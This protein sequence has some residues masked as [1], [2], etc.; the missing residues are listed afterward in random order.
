MQKRL[1]YKGRR[2]SVRVATAALVWLAAGMTT[3]EATEAADGKPAMSWGQAIMLG[4]IEGL[5]E[6]LPVSS[7]AHLFVAQR[8]MGIGD[9]AEERIAA[10]AF[11]IT[12]QAGAILAVVW[13]YFR[14]LRSIAAGLLGGAP[15]G[16][17]LAGR[18]LLAFLP[19][20]ALGLA[21]EGVI[22][23][24]LFNPSAIAAAWLAGGAAILIVGRRRGRWGHGARQSLEE[25]TWRGALLIG[26]AQCAALWPGVSRSLAT[27]VGGLLAG[28][29]VGAAVEFSFLLGLLTLGAATA[30]EMLRYGGE[31]I[32]LYGWFGPL[33]GLLT[34]LLT[35][36][37][38]VKWMVAWLHRHG[39]AIFGWYR[40]A[41]GLAAWAL[42]AAGRL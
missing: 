15:E 27:I 35:A 2:L 26:A 32:A 14:R 22:K 1:A 16:R 12:I 30:H 20:V 6:Y 3:T 34:G 33:L 18:L 21:A 36:A 29:G 13:L 4:A 10:D 39:L 11:V 23:E 42:I 28:L 17:R 19:A 31:I 40:V 37:A 7:T 5:T 9:T 8:L 24:K 41:A 25:L 38:S